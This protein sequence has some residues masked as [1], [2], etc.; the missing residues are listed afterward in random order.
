MRVLLVDDEEELVSTLA[1]RLAMRGI[2]ASWVTSSRS[3]IE[4]VDRED[5]D[6]AVLDVILPKMNGLELMRQ[7]GIRKPDVKFIFL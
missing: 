3:A 2:D 4:T 1:E 6:I 7:L 5:F